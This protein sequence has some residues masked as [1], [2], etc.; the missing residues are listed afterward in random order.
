NPPMPRWVV[1]CDE[2]ARLTVGNAGESR[3]ERGTRERTTALLCD[4]ARMGRAAGVHLV[5]CTQRPDADAVPGQLKANLAGTVA[6]RVRNE[7]NSRILLDCDRAALLPCHQGRA[8]WQDHQM[9]E[10][11]A[12][13]VSS[14]ECFERIETRWLREVDAFEEAGGISRWS[15]ARSKPWMPGWM[16]PFGMMVRE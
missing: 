12:I 9:E 2:L 4:I 13:H 10:F 15:P 8:I 14:D 6:F 7:A 11:Q 5:A 16:M 1:V 3:E